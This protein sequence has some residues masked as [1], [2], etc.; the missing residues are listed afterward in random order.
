MTSTSFGVTFGNGLPV[1]LVHAKLSLPP[2]VAVP[3]QFFPILCTPA[4]MIGPKNISV[5]A[6][7]YCV[8]PLFA[9]PWVLPTPL[10]EFPPVLAIAVD[11]TAIAAIAAI[12]T[13]LL[14]LMSVLLSFEGKWR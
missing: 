10:P 7:L 8:V 4:H 5:Y 12:V 3:G 14:N 6:L 11:G 2:D 9:P 13:A 1:V